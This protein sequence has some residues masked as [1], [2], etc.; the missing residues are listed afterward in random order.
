MQKRGVFVDAEDFLPV[1]GTY[2]THP[3]TQVVPNARN[4]EEL[5]AGRKA[6]Y[7]A[8]VENYNK[9]DADYKATLAPSK[10]YVRSEYLIEKPIHTSINQRVA[11]DS[12]AARQKAGL[13]DVM[14]EMKDEVV[15][16][17]QPL[18]YVQNPVFKTKASLEQHRRQ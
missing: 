5:T 2:P 16:S 18:A 3:L 15:A 11:E 1:T 8:D 10:T 7:K 12:V 9:K 4:I 14:Q 17:R 6:S 13:T